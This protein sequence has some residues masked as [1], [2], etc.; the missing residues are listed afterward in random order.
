MKIVMVH[1]HDIYHDLEPW[2]VR[3]TYLAQELI[4]AGHEIKL[5]YHLYNL[6]EDGEQTEPKQKFPFE[7]IPLS[8]H[9]LS[10]FHNTGQLE[11]FAWWADIVHFQKCSAYAALPAIAAAF[12]Q[13]RPVHYD[14]DDWEQAIFEHDNNNPVAAWLYFQQMEK[15]LLKLA[16]TV[17]VASTGLKDLCEKLKFP[18]ARTFLIPVGADLEVFSPEI[19]GAAVRKQYGWRKKLVIYQ[20]Q[21]CGANYVYLFIK[22]AR[23]ILNK[24]ADVDFVIVGGGDKLKDAKDLACRLEIT[25]GLTFTDKVPHE[26]VPQFIA[27]ADVAVAC[28]E[29]NQQVRC[30]SPLKVKEYMASGKAIVASRVGDLPE[31]LDG[32]GLLVEP[33]NHDEIA[34][35]I[36]QLLDDD[37]KRKLLGTKARARAERLYCWSRSAETLV[38]AYHK[39]I[40]IHHGL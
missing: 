36:E 35:A 22:A 31:M 9:P 19:S 30:K 20:G 8:R 26:M 23:I 40:E 3:I 27:A 29:D 1:P 13:G 17:S 2:T 32:C 4:R 16:D 37:N 11:K 34:A 38:A 39:A 6:P 25:K 14:W 18:A 15:H 24:R 21:I 10:I 12:Y 28:F 5:F 7:T 33:E